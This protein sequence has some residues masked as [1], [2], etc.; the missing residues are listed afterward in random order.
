MRDLERIQESSEE[1]GRP[2]A[3]VAVLVAVT[4][5][6]VFAL[7]LWVGEPEGQAEVED[8]LARLDTARMLAAATAEAAE[9]PAEESLFDEDG[10][11]V[12]P[13]VDETE[14]TFPETLGPAPE[15]PEVT[16][17]LAAAAAELAHPQPLDAPAVQAASATPSPAAM[18][19][20]RAVLD[21]TLRTTL[22]AGDAAG[23]T[24]RVLARTAPADPLVAAALPEPPSG[25]PSPPGHDG[26]YTLQVIS[27][28]SRENAES[29]AEG[30]RARGYRAF[31]LSAEVEGRG[32]MYRVRIG[33]FAD[34]REARDFRRTFEEAERMNTL[35]V[36]R[37]D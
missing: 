34:F 9:A 24:R 28:D 35:V 26:E 10:D 17:A 21:Q 16:A 6:L 30:L 4:V 37:R 14:L 2:L 19:V 22:P 1:G 5:A 33:P 36:R 12:E 23:S 32:T 27:Y 18:A 29:F 20:E 15:P 31:V 13:E 25:P 8:P 7:G 11:P 3:L